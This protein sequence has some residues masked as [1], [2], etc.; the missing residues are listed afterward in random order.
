MTQRGHD[1]PVSGSVPAD[2]RRSRLST[3]EFRKKKRSAA[4]DPR[5]CVVTAYDATFARMA[6]EAGVDAILVG[7]SL[8]MVV[9]GLD[10]TLPVTLEEMLYH[11]RA[12]N[13][14]SQRAHLTC[15]LPFLSYQASVD[16]AVRSAG[17]AL[18]EGGAQSVKI[19]GGRAMEGTIARLVSVGIPVMGHVGLTPQ[20]VH[21]MGGFRTQGLGGDEAR[22]LADARAVADAGAFAIVL[23]G[24]PASL[25]ERI[26]RDVSIPTIGIGA[27]PHCD[28]QVL[29][30]YDL[31]GLIPD[32]KPRFVKQYANLWQ[33]GVDAT[34]RYCTE[35]RDGVFPSDEHST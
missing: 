16:D 10:T 4:T 15:D 33:H 29:V 5:I 20:S 9:Q 11:C 18:K 6:E 35:V 30:G 3:P 24:I 34:K 12:V 13:R 26:T 22:V 21:A 32:F 19:E 31:L 8:G 28:G 14:G 27:G 23:E 1:S 17:R 2:P 25:A 7:D